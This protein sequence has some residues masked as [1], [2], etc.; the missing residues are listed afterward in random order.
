MK[1]RNILLAFLL[2]WLSGH[3]DMLAQ[4]FTIH[5]IGD[6][7]MEMKS[8]DTTVNPNGQ[9]GW[10]QMLS[11][12]T[13]N[14]AV[15]NNRAKSGTSSKTFYESDR[16]W[17]TV[18]PQIKAGDY[19][20]IQF[21]HN[22]EKDSGAEGEIGT[23]PWQSYIKYLRAYVDEVRALQA[24][25]ILFT[26][27]VRNRFT[28]GKITDA[29]AHN[30]GMGTDGKP[31]DY[32]A[33]MKSVAEEMNCQLV[34]HTALTKAICEE[35]GPSKTAELIYNVGDGTHLGEFGASLYAR[36]AVRD[37]I[38]QGIL[39]DY[40]NANPDLMVSPMEHDF[41]KC[42]LNTV[43]TYPFS[44][45]GMELTP[46][47]G[48][49]TITA[50]AG[51][52]VSA[53]ADGTYAAQIEIPYSDGYLSI[54]RF[55]VKFLSES[56][57]EKIG[58]LSIS[59]GVST[60]EVSLRGEGVSFAGGQKAS[61]YWELSKNE[62]AVVQGAVS[63]VP[64][65]FSNL[66]VDRYA[67]PGSTT[68][69]EGGKVDPEAKTQRIIIQGDNWPTGEIDMVHDRY[70]QF[71]VTATKGSVFNVDS[72]GLY[73]GGSGGNGMLFRVLCSKDPDFSES[74]MIADRSAGNVSNTM[75]PI[76]YTNIIEL[77]GEESLYVRVYPWYNNGSNRKSI[78]L[79]GMTVKGVVTE[80]SS[81]GM[82][83]TL[84]KDSFSYTASSERLALSYTLNQSAKVSI[85]LNSLSGQNLMRINKNKQ[86]AGKYEEE[87]NFSTAPKGIYL[88]SL[89]TDDWVKTIRVIKK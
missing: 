37:L 41:G 75:Y 51:F 84:E 13:V 35:Y 18:K 27:I 88:C 73:V 44:V 68:I 61:V 15:I 72:I 67:K 8:E 10:P 87:I 45:S 81:V 49:V 4:S 55:Y 24:T 71:G 60:K 50:P 47:N 53:A 80:D 65:K 5:T 38:R 25:P 56:V 54:T 43:F 48:N 17:P 82:N 29:G 83:R 76:S 86:E 74:V 57:G 32:V 30:I 6:S 23:N 7:T 19:V 33:A 79:Y 28:D 9:R 70:I 46:G 42:Y 14:G 11:A 21:G 64:Q 52:A 89:I 39:T 34:D 69:W 2:S 78:C 31:L 1:K 66:Y 12:F 85:V 77:K 26:P 62:D 22:D 63:M 16:F 58:K 20:L 40:L 3:S 36:L 59:N